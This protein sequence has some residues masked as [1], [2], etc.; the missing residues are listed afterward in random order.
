MIN[1]D[2]FDTIS[3]VEFSELKNIFVSFLENDP[4]SLLKFVDNFSDNYKSKYPDFVI[5]EGEIVY[6]YKIADLAYDNLAPNTYSFDMNLA[7]AFYLMAG[8]FYECTWDLLWVLNEIIG[9][10]KKSDP[11]FLIEGAVLRGWVNAAGDDLDDDLILG[12]DTMYSLVDY[13]DLELEI[14]VEDYN[15]L[16]ELCDAIKTRMLSQEL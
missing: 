6:P 11:S 16:S 12:G 5:D 2:H 9:K 8:S 4:A 3:Q 14:N 13:E 10:Y 15:M 7:K 1:K